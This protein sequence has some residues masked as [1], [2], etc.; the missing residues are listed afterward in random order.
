MASSPFLTPGETADLNQL[1]TSEDEFLLAL[2]LPKLSRSR[3]DLSAIH[4]A[5]ARGEAFG[6]ATNQ[7]M[8]FRQF[9]RPH[10]TA[11]FAVNLAPMIT[12]NLMWNRRCWKV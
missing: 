1:L 6:R 2:S 8:R 3:R 12:A 10:L 11:S 9:S 5:V 7:F 4:E